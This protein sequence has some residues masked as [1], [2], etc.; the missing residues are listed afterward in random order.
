MPLYLTDEQQML[1]DTAKDFVAEHAPVSHMRHLR[2][3]NDANGFSRDLWKSFAD[4]GLTGIL[5][6]EADNGL[7]LGHVEAGVVLGDGVTVGDDCVLH[8]NVVLYDGVS[9]GN[10]VILHAGVC[11]G[12]DGFGYVRHDLGYQKFPQVGTVVIDVDFEIGELRF[13]ERASLGRSR[14]GRCS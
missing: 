10:R 4:L 2:D 8:P 3:T 9:V 11:V 12:A 13:V 6:P 7:G 1:R 14:L 5:I